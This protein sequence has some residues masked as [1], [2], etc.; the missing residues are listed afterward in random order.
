MCLKFLAYLLITVSIFEENCITMSLTIVENKRQYTPL[1]I[2]DV[3]Y[4][5]H[6]LRGEL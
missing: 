5:I 4:S 1:Q 6:T 3:T 2:G